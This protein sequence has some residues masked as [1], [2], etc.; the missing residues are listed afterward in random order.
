M[1]YNKIL[2][3][4]DDINFLNI[5]K[6]LLSRKNYNVETINNSK[7][8]I[9]IIKRNEFDI[10]ITDMYMP[11]LNGLE[12][13]KTVKQLEPCIDIILITG[14]GSIDN[15]VQAIKEGAFTYIQKPV[16]IDELFL[17][18]EKIIEFKKIK[19][20]N[21]FLKD[22]LLKKD[23]YFI[24]NDKKTLEMKRFILEVAK[25]NTSVLITGE[26][27]TGKEI[28]AKAIHNNSNRSHE[29]LVKVNCSAFSEGIME[30]E[31]FGHEKGSFTGATSTKE[32]RFEIANKGTLFLDE[33]GEISHNIQVKLLRVIQE[34]E[35]E[36]V[37]G[38]KT[39][40]TDFRLICA[41]NKN[42]LEE[43]K[44]GNFREDL[45]YRLN[46][47]PIKV[48][49][50]RERKSDIPLLINYFTHLYSKET[51][52]K[53]IEYTNDA[54]K[55]LTDYDWPGNI[56]ELKNV[57]ER[58]IVLTKDYN[59]GANDVIKCVHIDKDIEQI[60]YIK[61][62]RESKQEFE[63]NYIKQVLEIHGFN[64]TKTAEFMGI[65]RKNLQAKIKTLNIKTY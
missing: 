36:R 45:Y 55:V 18:L 7:T 65:A 12:L 29:N 51:N 8:A 19:H 60:K 56:R 37:G 34:K 42:L 53:N 4:D 3:V 16:N 46:V 1:L 47:I 44:K 32:G 5:Y 28:V 54:I 62:F 33:I 48:P 21:K 40:K 11:D 2:M 50:L 23:E 26:S 59:I 15:A 22:E 10:L 24:G 41:T 58:L 17:N 43:I 31:L 63:T 9:E 35:F 13:I 61:P 38:N 57:I 39:I 6:K 52:K 25:S 49:P 27:G 14:N 64:V 20:E 30:S